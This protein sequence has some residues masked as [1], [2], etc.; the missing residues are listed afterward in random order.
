MISVSHTG[1]SLPIEIYTVTV[2]EGRHLET[3]QQPSQ[4]LSENSGKDQFLPFLSP[5]VAS[6]VP[7]LTDIHVLPVYFIWSFLCACVSALTIPLWIGAGVILDQGPLSWNHLHLITASK[8]LSLSKV[9]SK[10]TSGYD[11]RGKILLPYIFSEA[12]FNPE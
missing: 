10:D 12:K 8:T 6:D 9:P 1:W 3:S 5:P 4:T 2:L 11:F 7:C